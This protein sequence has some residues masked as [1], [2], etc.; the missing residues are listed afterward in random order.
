MRFLFKGVTGIMI[1][2]TPP[3]REVFAIIFKNYLVKD[4]FSLQ[5]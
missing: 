1:L 5:E 3:A 2:D 4:E